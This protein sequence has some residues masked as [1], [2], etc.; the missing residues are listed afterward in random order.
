VFQSYRKIYGKSNVHC[1][2]MYLP[3]FP[4]GMWSFSFSA[5]GG[6]GPNIDYKKD[7]IDKFCDVNRL[8]YYSFDIHKA[9]FILPKFVWDILQ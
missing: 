7:E 3:S 2:L 4:S 9:A 1:Y 6:L 5:K 8:K